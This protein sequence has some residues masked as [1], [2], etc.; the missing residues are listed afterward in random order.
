LALNG[1]HGVIAQQTELGISTHDSVHMKSVSQHIP[2]ATS[3][4]GEGRD[5]QKVPNTGMQVLAM[6]RCQVSI[7]LPQKLSYLACNL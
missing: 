2:E 3:M 1:L 6:K 4:N 5:V 7:A